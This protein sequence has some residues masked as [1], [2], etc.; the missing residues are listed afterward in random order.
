VSNGWLAAVNLAATIHDLALTGPLEELKYIARGALTMPS[1]RTRS[2]N[3]TYD[4][5]AVA[6]AIQLSHDCAI[7][8]D[9]KAQLD[10][11][12][13]QLVVDLLIKFASLKAQV[14]AEEEAFDRLTQKDDDPKPFPKFEDHIREHYSTTTAAN[15]LLCRTL[16]PITRYTSGE[17]WKKVIKPNI[18]LQTL[19]RLRDSQ[20]SQ[21]LYDQLQESAWRKK[22]DAGKPGGVLDQLRKRCK[23]VMDS[24]TL[25]RAG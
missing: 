11:L 19:A 15:L 14:E 12:P 3:F 21:E 4:S 10:A 20:S 13:T 6:E 9:A 1:L 17:W 5:K 23:Q 25:F 22:N 16:P 24:K 18:N 2:K 8:A 7:N